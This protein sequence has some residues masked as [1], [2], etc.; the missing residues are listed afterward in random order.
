MERQL[1][2]AQGFDAHHSFDADK[3]T[4][5][6]GGAAAAAATVNFTGKS[7]AEAS[8]GAAAEQSNSSSSLGSPSAASA[9]APL[10]AKAST[11][12]DFSFL[13]PVA[14]KIV[15]SDG[16]KSVVDPIS[17]AISLLQYCLDFP[18]RSKYFFSCSSTSKVL[19]CV[20]VSSLSADEYYSI[21]REG[22]G[23]A[24]MDA[25]YITAVGFEFDPQARRGVELAP[26]AALECT[27]LSQTA[28]H[29]IVGLPP[30]MLRREAEKTEPMAE[31][32]L[33]FL[34]P[35]SKEPG[36][37]SSSHFWLMATPGEWVGNEC[38]DWYAH[39]LSANQ[40]T[41]DVKLFSSDLFN[42]ALRAGDKMDRKL[43]IMLADCPQRSSFLCYFQNHWTLTT[44]EKPIKRPGRLCFMDSLDIFDSNVTKTFQDVFEKRFGKVAICHLN[45]GAQKEKPPTE[46]GIFTMQNM[47]AFMKLEPFFKVAE[48]ESAAKQRSSEGCK[49]ARN[50]YAA[51]LRENCVN[52]LRHGTPVSLAG[53]TKEHLSRSQSEV[54][55]LS[56]TDDESA[57]VPAPE[58]RPKAAASKARPQQQPAKGQVANP[59][60]AATRQAAANPTA[61]ATP[62]AA[63]TL[64][65]ANP[66]MATAEKNEDVCPLC[67]DKLG[68]NFDCDACV[69]YKD[70]PPEIDRNKRRR[71]ASKPFEQVTACCC[72]AAAAAAAAAAANN[73]IIAFFS[74]Y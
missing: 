4:F 44:F 16:Y 65:A 54:V 11:K 49:V 36:A 69:M 57:P 37:V 30:V 24:I 72:V 63:T 45:G 43:N 27:H 7:K 14:A 1:K 32:I 17:N 70:H 20:F 6:T 73:L 34:V 2:A 8:T 39:F 50:G 41:S 74:Y 68:R 19:M 71:T 12:N 55:V 15:I 33:Q 10:Q 48:W 58:V 40:R 26:L 51:L 52:F 22:F 66:A 46:C 64:K 31:K 13:A 21:T 35:G 5:D 60:T 67:R 28:T 18:D 53:P 56:D 3:T 61:A 9:S 25:S 47:E 59:K 62:K 29:C 38:L 23:E 42:V